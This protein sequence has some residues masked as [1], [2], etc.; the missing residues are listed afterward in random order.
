MALGKI[1]ADTLE[2]STAGAVDTLYVVNGS[3]KVRGSKNTA[4]TSITGTLNISSLDDDGT[5]LAGINFSSAFSSA[6]YQGLLSI[7]VGVTAGNSAGHYAEIN[8]KVAGACDTKTWYGDASTN[9]TFIDW[10]Y[11][12]IIHGDLA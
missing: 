2:H 9:A 1:K 12:I 11:D 4:G 5:G 7:P 8:S 10:P 3:A 6:T